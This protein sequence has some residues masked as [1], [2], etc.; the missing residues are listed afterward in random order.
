MSLKK[1][2]A[3]ARGENVRSDC[4]VEIGWR[5]RGNREI[6]IES[7]VTSMYG[8]A[9]REQLNALSSH[10][11]VAN[12]KIRLED[13]G[14]VPYVVAARF[15]AA[16]RRTH[17]QAQE[18]V[19]PSRHKRQPS[20]K[21]RARRSRL[22]LPGNEPKF[23]LNA[24][25]HAPD[26]VILDLEDSVPPDEKDAA[27]ILVR[28]ALCAAN[29]RQCEVSVRINQGP[30]GIEDLRVVAPHQVQV[31][32]IP[33]VETAQQVSDVEAVLH[34]SDKKIGRGWRTLVIPI[35]ES[36]LGIVR[37]YEIASSSDRVC[38]LAIGLEDYT[39]DIGVPRTIEGRESLYARLAVVNAAKAAGV[40]ALDSVFS[41]VTAVE[42]LV[43]S[44]AES[45]ALG[46]D[47]KG[48]IHPRQI[49]IIHE[50]FLPSEDEIKRAEDIVVAYDLAR[51]EGKSVVA[52]GSKMIDAPVVKW[53]HMIIAAAVASGKLSKQWRQNYVLPEQQA[54]SA[55]ETS[56]A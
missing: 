19:I 33:K 53:A 38:A 3:G 1:T 42:E 27:R 31:V 32:Y 47:G 12:A 9:L 21:D 34:E 30:L 26:G 6:I 45:R 55:N 48:C 11:S 25:L 14:A 7:K 20:T 44:T 41:D 4:F 22:Y 49:R 8:T 50:A 36:A 10:F 15:E 40:Q 18:Y 24:A 2:T 52:L 54:T 13:K 51:R 56:E 28:N 17:A 29:F 35:V 39:A 5:S 46:F 43:R 23:F 16:V 37:A